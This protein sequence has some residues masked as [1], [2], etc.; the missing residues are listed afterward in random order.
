MWENALEKPHLDDTHEAFAEWDIY[1]CA[2]GKTQIG[3]ESAED[4]RFEGK[5]SKWIYV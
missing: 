4:E 1:E 2:Q 3:Y 5:R